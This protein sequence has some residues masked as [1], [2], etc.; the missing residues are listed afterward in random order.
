MDIHGTPHHG[1]P[2]KFRSFCKNDWFYSLVQG[3]TEVFRKAQTRLP[4]LSGPGALGCDRPLSM[5]HSPVMFLQAGNRLNCC[6]R[7]MYVA[8]VLLGRTG[9]ITGTCL[10]SAKLPLSTDTAM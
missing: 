1:K 7:E 6:A 8:H 3:S 4:Q 5:V 10:A 9:L 2:Q